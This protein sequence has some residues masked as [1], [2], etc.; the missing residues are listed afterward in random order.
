MKLTLLTRGLCG[1]FIICPNF[2]ETDKGTFVVQGY[3]VDAETK[4]DI[5]LSNDEDAVEI[6]RELVNELFQ[7]LSK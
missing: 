6:P 7:V 1:R 5:Q 3:K 4:K 2:Y